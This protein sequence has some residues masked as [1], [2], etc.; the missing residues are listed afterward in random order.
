MAAA[1]RKHFSGLRKDVR[2]V[3]G[4][5]IRRLEAAMVAR[6]T[7]TTAEFGDLF[8]GHPLTRHVA[9]RLVWVAEADGARTT[10][11]L[12]ED[13]VLGGVEDEILT[14][15]DSASIHLAHPLELAGELGAWSEV[16]ADHEI[17]QPFPQLGRLVHILT[18]EERAGPRLTRF[19]GLTVPTGRLL[20]IQRRGWARGEPQDA[21]IEQWLSREVG[22]GC[23][24]VLDLEPGIAA[25]RVEE[26]SE[27]T[28]RT[29]RLGGC[30][31]G[32][33]PSRSPAP[34]F[35]DLDPVTASEILADL[36]QLT[37]PD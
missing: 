17:L 6:R 14:L 27:Q 25:G 36:T 12:T 33:R 13:R 29:V 32:H 28:L 2:T 9:R 20:E 23:F 37:R 15:P 1:A 4:D 24:L 22:P 21:G 16:F 5:L 31:G 30:P 26:F 8:T 18:D 19:E 3:A 11:R 35:A 10:F 7:W 34:R